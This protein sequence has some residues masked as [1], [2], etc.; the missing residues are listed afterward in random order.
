MEISTFNIKIPGTGQNCILSSL[1][2]LSNDIIA[3]T[4]TQGHNLNE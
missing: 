2:Y 1:Q 3:P 4:I